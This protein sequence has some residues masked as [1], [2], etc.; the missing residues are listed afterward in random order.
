MNIVTLLND[1]CERNENV[2]Y[3]ERLM[4]YGE[5]FK[6]ID[7][8]SISLE[9]YFSR[10]NQYM[11]C[12]EHIYETAFEYVQRLN[13]IYPIQRLYA[14]KILFVSILIA[15]KFEEDFI[16]RNDY[17]AQIS[18]ISSEDLMQLEVAFCFLLKFKLYINNK[19]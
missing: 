8:P 12:D 9:A 15:K 10:L 14:H 18:G 2:I 7:S 13:Q 1:V 6:C 17:Y 3:P 11:N 16:E 19:I 4:M 5:L